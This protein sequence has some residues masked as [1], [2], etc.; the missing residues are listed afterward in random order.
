[1]QAPRLEQAQ[2]QPTSQGVGQCAVK[3]EVVFRALSRLVGGA[4]QMCEGSALV[5]LGQEN[6]TDHSSGKEAKPINKGLA[7]KHRS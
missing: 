2:T 5:C 4:S 6:Q 3:S 1:M 7:P